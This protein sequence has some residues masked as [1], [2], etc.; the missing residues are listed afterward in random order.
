M[1]EAASTAPAPSAAK[2]R[3]S[4]NL[5]GMAEGDHAVG[6]DV[7]AT[8]RAHN[9][10]AITVRGETKMRAAKTM[11]LKPVNLGNGK[12]KAAWRP[13]GTQL[14]VA[15]EKVRVR[16]P[17]RNFHGAASISACMRACV[18]VCGR[19]GSSLEK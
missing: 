16:D 19:S 17:L 15:S 6:G 12:V 4:L 2:S 13:A 14:A 18:C 8:N 3:L 1:A 10:V 5:N 7:I 11:Q 9:E